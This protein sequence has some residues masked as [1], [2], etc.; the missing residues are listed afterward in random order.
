M[1]IE[2]DA[3]KLLGELDAIASSQVPFAASVA[4]GRL[5]W[6]L[7]NTQWPQ[8]ASRTFDR[9]VPF[10]TGGPGIQGG[11]LYDHDRGSTE[12]TIRLDRDAPKGQS[13]D[14]YLFPGSQGGEIYVTRFTRALRRKG[15][16]PP[17]YVA[18]PWTAGR[19]VAPEINSYGNVRASFY[20]QTLAGL[21]R[22]GG[23]GER[24]SKTGSYKYFSVPDN[25]SGIKILGSGSK[26]FKGT[27]LKEG[28]YRVKGSQLDFL[29]GYAKQTPTVPAKWDFDDFA[30]EAASKVLPGLLSKAL[31]DALR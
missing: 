18:L 23:L 11:L 4:M 21:A 13:P 26:Q 28:I 29:F 24:R 27:E 2:F 22:R 6:E 19:A 20:T 3:T 7:K 16:V 25:R 30:N 15:I 14:R 12:L 31:D 17:N 9:P 10:T 1:A 8:Y 5:G